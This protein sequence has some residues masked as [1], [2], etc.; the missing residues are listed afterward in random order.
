MLWRECYYYYYNIHH[1]NTYIF[2]LLI[3]ISHRHMSENRSDSSGH[4]IKMK[5][6]KR[7]NMSEI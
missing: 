1:H 4:W 6:D 5:N 7:V 2:I 3:G